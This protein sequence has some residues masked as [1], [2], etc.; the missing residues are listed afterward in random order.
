MLI[1]RWKD[2]DVSVWFSWQACSQPRTMPHLW[3]TRNNRRAGLAWQKS[4]GPDQFGFVLFCFVSFIKIWFSINYSTKNNVFELA[5]GSWK[6]Y[7][8]EPR[9]RVVGAC[10]GVFVATFLIMGM[11]SPKWIVTE[12]PAYVVTIPCFCAI[13]RAS[14]PHYAWFLVLGCFRAAFPNLKV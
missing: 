7:V 9:Y 3:R 12:W 8:C 4:A 6:F 2:A 14:Y 5:V 10:M 11:A 13:L 1:R